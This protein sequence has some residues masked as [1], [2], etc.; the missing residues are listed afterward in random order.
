M[1]LEKKKLG[2]IEVVTGCMFAG[3]TEELIRQVHTLTRTNHNVLVVK[4]A[5]DNRYSEQEVVSHSG[6]RLD[7]IKVSN[8]R[9]ILDH[10][11]P[12]VD[13][14]AIDEIQFLGTD[15]VRVVDYLAD[16]G[17]IIFASGLDT[18]FRGEPFGVMPDLLA[19]ATKVTKLSSFC[20]VC[21][22]EANRTQRLINGSPASYY[23]PIVLV[24]ASEAYEP[25]C[26]CCHEVLDKP[27]YF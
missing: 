7:A 27:R 3:K 15:V 25:R 12:E 2:K 14:V 13:A 22:V 5:I 17:I 11:T 18:D 9:E 6:Y 1:D 21:G 20:A 24:G 8:A 10:I 4:P 19:R 26:R 23:D 16:L